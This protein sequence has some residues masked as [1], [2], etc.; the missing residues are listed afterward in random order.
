MG[1]E[2]FAANLEWL[3]IALFVLGTILIAIELVVPGFGIAGI[4]GIISLILGVKVAADVVAPA[5]LVV[6]IAIILIVIAFLVIWF[7]RSM[8]KGGRLSKTLVLSSKLEDDE[9]YVAPR[10]HDILLDKRGK[11][12][13]MLRPTGTAEF[14]GEKVDVVTEGE[15]IGPGREIEVIKVEGFK[16]VVREVEDHSI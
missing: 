13:T 14:D 11:T 1:L 3:M 4:L 8:T 9:G 16:V 7:Y 2:I 6:L 12:L 15:F 10:D 5:V